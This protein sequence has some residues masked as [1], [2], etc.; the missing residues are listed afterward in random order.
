MIARDAALGGSHSTPKSVQ[1]AQI[2]RA[3]ESYVRQQP[4]D[5]AAG[6]DDCE[7]ALI[8]LAAVLNFFIVIFIGQL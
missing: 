5:E 1:V 4:Q 2:Y 3:E 8:Q 7:G 6:Q